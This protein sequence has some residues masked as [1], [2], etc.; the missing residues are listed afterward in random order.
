ML[1]KHGVVGNSSNFM[2]MGWI[3]YRWR[4][5]PHCQYVA[6][7]WCH[8]WLLPNRC[9][10][11]DYMRLSG[12]SEDQVELVENMPKRRACGVTRAMNQFLPVLRTGYE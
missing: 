12:R 9:C 4:I 5:A 1:R 8:L 10:T 2:V 3:H 7:I 6:R 11:L